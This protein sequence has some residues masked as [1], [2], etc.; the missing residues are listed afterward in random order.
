[1]IFLYILQVLNKLSAYWSH[2]DRTLTPWTNWAP[3]YLSVNLP[4]VP[5]QFT[6]KS[7][8]HNLSNSH[9]SP[10]NDLLEPEITAKEVFDRLE[11]QNLQI[12][13]QMEQHQRQLQ[14]YFTEMGREAR[15]LQSLI[16]RAKNK[17]NSESVEI[18][19]NAVSAIKSHRNQNAKK[20][21]QTVGQ[22]EIFQY[23]ND[24]VRRNYMKGKALKKKVQ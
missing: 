17:P 8:K 19:G 12:A 3:K 5:P 10:E 20:S 4:F 15:K 14:N 1:M 16:D 2:K 21:E 24:D 23:D 13:A 7:Q 11:D 18:D 22:V 9:F 6:A